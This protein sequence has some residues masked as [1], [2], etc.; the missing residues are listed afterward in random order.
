M[1]SILLDTNALLW[2]A[3]PPDRIAASARDVLGDRTNELFVSVV[4]AWEVAMKTLIGRLNGAPLLS[5]WDEVLAGMN[6]TE[7]VIDSDD[8]TMASQLDWERKDPFDR[9][10]VAQAARRALTIATSDNQLIHGALTPV[11]VTR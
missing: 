7:L 2:L 6:A 9:M 11:L 8:A 4:S 1:T 10:I 5:A 3:S